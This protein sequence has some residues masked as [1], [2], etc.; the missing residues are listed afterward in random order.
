MIKII[1]ATV[2]SW[3]KD[4]YEKFKEKHNY[5]HLKLIDNPLDLNVD[6]ISTFQPDYIFFPHWN[7][8]IPKEI[9][10]FY[11]CIVFH[12]TDL[13]FGRGGSPL[14][15]LIIRGIKHTKIS[16]IKVVSQLDAGDIYLKKDLSLSGRAKDIYIRA[17][18][19]IF[20]EM[21]P[22]IIN[23]NPKPIKQIGNPVY[24]SRR[25][26]S[27]SELSGDNIT[28][29]KLYDFIRMLDA[30]GYPNAF[31]KSNGLKFTFNKAKLKGQKLIAQVEIEEDK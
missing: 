20:E 17:S 2:K 29:E 1:V 19:I 25:K 24:F 31:L 14:Q 10:E 9:Y 12:M 3:N 11:N 30:D 28:L 23:H 6:N 15:N 18:K 13:P 4:Y 5:Y 8:I 22:Y 27:Q 7:N 21:I 16:A 26:P